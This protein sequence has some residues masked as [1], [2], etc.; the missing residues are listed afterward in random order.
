LI[1]F[2]QCVDRLFAFMKIILTCIPGQVSYR[3]KAK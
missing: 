1:E 3:F 2:C